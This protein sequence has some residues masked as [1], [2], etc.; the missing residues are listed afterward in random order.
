[1][2]T[3]KILFLIAIV[4]LVGFSQNCNC[5][6]NYNWVKKTFEE[7]DAGYLLALK[8]KGNIAY[9]KHN[10]VFER[11]IQLI[12]DA[13]ECELALREWLAFFRPGHLTIRLLSTKQSTSSSSSMNNEEIIEKYK[14]WDNISTTEVE[15]KDY[16]QSKSEFDYEGIWV[17][18]P[19]KIGIKKNNDKYLGFIIDGDGVYWRKGQIK[20]RIAEDTAVYYMRNHSASKFIDF[21]LI[22]NNYL[23]IGFITLK[24]V[25]PEFDTDK[26]TENYIKSISAQKPFSQRLSNSTILLR[27]PSFSGSEKKLIDSVIMANNSAL[28]TTENLILDLRNNSGGSDRSY[29]EILPYLYT[30]PV[31]KV[32]VEFL[33]TPLNNKTIERYLN[34]PNISEEDLLWVKESLGKLQSNPGRFVNLNSSRVTISKLDSVYEYPQNIGIIIN[35]NN[36]STAEQF[37]L[38]AKQSRKVKLF[39]TTTMGVLDIS[40]MNFVVSP[41]GEFQLG[42]CLSKSM[43]IPE[44][45]IDNK[46]IQPD[47]YIDKD[48]PKYKWIEFVERTLNEN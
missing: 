46:G 48:I 30:N 2:K 18:G 31:R 5:L 26:S 17:S 20:L 39:G 14:D 25:F 4:P 21:E 40:N 19:Y 45:T 13:K 35:E 6:D 28:S 15:F 7:N 1:M 11:K 3:I 41:S 16:L 12:T 36:G 23:Q 37:L 27:I 33:S 44:M 22:G 9:E 38:A 42:Y 24:R 8:Q 10:E 34:D 47:Y 29:K 43:R 32:G